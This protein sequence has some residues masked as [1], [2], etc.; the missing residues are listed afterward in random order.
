[1]VNSR[2]NVGHKIVSVSLHV[3]EL[4]FVQHG[5]IGRSDFSMLKLN[6]LRICH[7]WNSYSCVMEYPCLLGCYHEN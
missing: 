2:Y 6:R 4:F 3:G 7:I 1:M 5:I